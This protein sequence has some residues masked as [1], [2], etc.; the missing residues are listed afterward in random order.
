VIFSTQ[1][2]SQA[3]A[4][5]KQLVLLQ[6]M[7][8]LSTSMINQVDTLLTVHI[9]DDVVQMLCIITVVHIVL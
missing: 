5:T 8:M 7:C 2:Q 1:L 3:P 9:N 4:V 6:L